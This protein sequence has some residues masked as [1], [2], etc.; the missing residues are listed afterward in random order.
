MTHAVSLQPLDEVLA[1][2]GDSIHV[3]KLLQGGTLSQDRQNSI[4]RC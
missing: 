2:T 1:N 4:L 3:E